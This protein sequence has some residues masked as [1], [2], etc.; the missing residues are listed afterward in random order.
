VGHRPWPRWS[1]WI[2]CSDRHSPYRFIAEP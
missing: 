2:S 1:S